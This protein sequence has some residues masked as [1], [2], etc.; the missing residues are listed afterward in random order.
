MSA[1]SVAP[2]ASALDRLAAAHGL[3]RSYEDA[4]G[5]KRRASDEATLAVLRALGVPIEG[6]ADAEDALRARRQPPV[7]PAHLAGAPLP[8]ALTPGTRVALKLT[9]EGAA[10]RRVEAAV[11]A[12]GE[13]ALPP[14]PE[15]LHG[16]VVG[17]AAGREHH[18]LLI[19]APAPLE[20]PTAAGF[21]VFAPLY[22]LHDEHGEVGDF[23]TLG[24]MAGA[25]AEAGAEGVVTLPLLPLLTEPPWNECSPYAA[26]SRL[27]WNELFV[28]L[29][30]SP[31]REASP[32]AQRL[33]GA[34]PALTVP[35]PLRPGCRHV[36][37]PALTAHRSAALD[38]L[39]ASVAGDRALAFAAFLEAAPNVV[40]YA[41]H[42]AAAH[43]AP[44]RARVALRHRYGQWLARAQLSELA[45]RRPLHL[46]LP[47]GVH[48]DAYDVAAHAE[49]YVSGVAAGAPPDPLFV[50][51]QNWGFPP[52]HPGR[53]RA[54]GYA[55]LIALLEHHLR[56]AAS[57]RIDHVAWLRRLFWIPAGMPGSEGLYVRHEAPEELFALV[58]L[59]GRRHGCRIVGEDLGTVP[60][61]VRASM[62]ERGL[63]R[64][65]VFQFGARATHPCWDAPPHVSVV[66]LDTHD[67]ATFAGW[68]AG[69]DI[70][71][72][73]ALGLT[74]EADA[75]EERA[76]RASLTAGI[77]A[78]LGLP[79]EVGADAAFAALAET[80]AGG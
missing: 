38:A 3:E 7:P 76:G 54:S 78:A 31:E 26:A 53:L 33:L 8:T 36:D 60:P 14:V 25:L 58:A 75:E 46:D 35:D 34:R 2:A 5:T 13:I 69:D 29:A 51:G 40:A 12:K 55:H 10:P 64:T 1:P 39:A 52:L 59:L 4:L 42:R 32:E 17:D 65:W 23:G 73:V 6:A 70:D 45:A 63:R 47:L 79:G 68:W 71:E 28:D 67:T 50:G 62:A 57:L 37:W 15:G 30:A 43:A 19:A 18:C 21:T 48:P 9:P 44:E 66:A 20:A 41:A 24:R 80:L 77:A 49:L 72:R 56:P 74:T 22:A 16:L 11:G 61:E 27:Q